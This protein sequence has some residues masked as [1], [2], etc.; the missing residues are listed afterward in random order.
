MPVRHLDMQQFRTLSTL[1]KTGS[2][3][4]TARQLCKTQSAITHQIHRLENT[5]G[6]P[7]FEKQ[8]RN[9]VLTED[10]HKLLQYANKMLALN[11]EIFRVFQERQTQGV[12]RLGAPH[13][14]VETLLPSILRFINQM[15]PQVWVDTRI[16]RAP[17]LL[18]LLRSGETD[19]IIS[20]RFCQDF[21][22]LVLKRSPTVWL[23]A[24]DYIHRPEEPIPLILAQGTSIYREMAVAALE[25]AHVRWTVSRLVPDLVSIKTAIRAGM[26][27]TPRS[28]DLL[29]PDMRILGE[30]EHL[31]PLP[32]ITF[33]LWI[34][35]LP[36]N[37]PAR[38]AYDMLQNA[39]HLSHI[40]LSSL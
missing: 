22:G 11:D 31:P 1:A 14:T 8:G 2:F 24:A 16:E 21:E 19:I 7:L 25:Q 15:L 33:H 5:L 4:A 40:S 10:G 3:T 27:I 30:D 23:C 26:G 12:I 13:D 36:E 32:E 37:S 9:R 29:A 17:K 6:I 38:Q 39:W 34:R 20:A 35:S 28:I 18:E